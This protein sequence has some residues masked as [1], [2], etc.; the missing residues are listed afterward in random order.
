MADLPAGRQAR[1]K[2]MYY[3]YV[4]SSIKRKYIYVGLTNNLER[5]FAQHQLGR[6]K[7]TSPYKPFEILITEVYLTRKDA[8]KREVYLKSGAG[9]EW[10]KGSKINQ[11]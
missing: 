6:E 3:V 4:L 9:K 11:T 10:I 5:R 8:R 2:S 1:T 7:T